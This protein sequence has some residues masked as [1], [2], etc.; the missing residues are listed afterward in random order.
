MFSKIDFSKLSN[1]TPTNYS[2]IIDKKRIFQEINIEL[3]R[4]FGI[5][6]QNIVIITGNREAKQLPSYNTRGLYDP[7]TNTI[8]LNM[9]NHMNPYLLLST[10]VHETTHI[11]LSIAMNKYIATDNINKKSKQK[12]NQE[13]YFI[14]AINELKITEKYLN[15]LKLDKIYYGKVEDQPY[16]YNVDSSEVIAELMT[17]K[18]MNEFFK[19]IKMDDIAILLAKEAIRIMDYSKQG[20][21]ELKKIYVEENAKDKTMKMNKKKQD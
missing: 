19:K 16:F 18:F 6:S 1:F 3:S 17:Y 2:N 21:K 15:L 11:F 12:T 10:L 7:K 9:Y 14:K 20:D 8:Y 5:E 4:V 13:Q